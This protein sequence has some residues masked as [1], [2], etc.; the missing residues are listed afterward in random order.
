MAKDKIIVR[1]YAKN[2]AQA[3]RKVA[4]VADL[5]RGRSVEDALVIL[6]HV[7][8]RAATPVKKAIESAKAN[9]SFNHNLDANSLMLHTVSVTAGKRLKRFIPASRG[10]ALPFEKKSCNILIEVTGPEKAKPK[11]K[12][13]P[14]KKPATKTT[15]KKEE[16]K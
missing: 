1:A 10:R 3:P 4:I 13:I 7:P 15:A 12:A 2:V 5:V 8:R 6:S 9:A 11:A 16:K 14:A